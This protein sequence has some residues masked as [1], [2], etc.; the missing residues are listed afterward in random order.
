MSKSRPRLLFL[1]HCLP[2]PADEGVKIRTFNVLRLLARDFDV[3]ALCLYRRSGHESA[4]AVD[5]A[6]EALR[7][8]A[9]VRAYP[10]PQEHDRARL[11]WDHM[12]SL[13][14]GCAYTHFAYASRAFRADLLETLRSFKPDL[15]HVDSL[16]LSCY[17]A[18]L[19][20]GV[21][22]I[23]AHHNVESALLHRRAESG[24]VL[25]KWYL[26]RQGRLTED[27]ERRWVPKMRLNVA[28]SDL[29]R[30]AY[31]R[32]TG[33]ATFI[34]VPN[35]V[36]TGEFQALGDP[37]GGVVFVGGS[38]WH[39]NRDALEFFVAEILPRLRD[40]APKT[41]ITWVGQCSAEDQVRMK[42][43]HGID[44]T[45]HVESIEPHVRAAACFIVPL[46]IGGGT[47]LKILYAWSM[48]RAVVTTSLGC[49]GLDAVDGENVLIRDSPAAFADAIL[50]VLRSPEL[51]QRLAGAGR[52][53]VESR[54]DWEVIAR[55]MLS[56]YHAQL[57]APATGSPP[58]SEGGI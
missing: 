16:D 13:S 48:A 42:Q 45:G 28:V 30:A 43:Q 11:L 10:I 1:S 35:G 34:V 36:D 19:P 46:R 25:R 57:A 29:D 20:V 5:M 7:P 37:D 26:H 2:F 31:L 38:T 22:V 6:V 3:T 52:A 17:L 21:P 15:V 49:E 55:A 40:R 27:L 51:R 44:M 39:P 41:G 58:G 24:S 32:I 47:R 8:F 9:R 23:C 50:D 14:L 18:A 56:A 54:Y 4:A 12:R 53:L 33:P